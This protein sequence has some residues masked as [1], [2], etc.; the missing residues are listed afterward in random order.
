[1][2]SGRLREENFTLLALKVVP[3]AYGWRSLTRGSNYRDL[4]E[5]LLAAEE[6]W[7]QREVPLL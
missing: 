2:L 6:R 3:V 7:S 5:T 1:M 4:T